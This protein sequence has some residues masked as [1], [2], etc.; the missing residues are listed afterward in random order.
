MTLLK[1]QY[2]K[3]ANLFKKNTEDLLDPELYTVEVEFSAYVGDA[4]GWKFKANPD[5]DWNNS[6]WENGNEQKKFHLL[7]LFI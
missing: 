5:E 2:I 1:Q 7:L 3:R 6:G 4:V